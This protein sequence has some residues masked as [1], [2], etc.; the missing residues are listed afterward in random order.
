MVSDLARAGASL[1]AL[2]GR[3]VARLVRGAVTQRPR[4]LELTVTALSDVHKRATF[5]QSVRRIAHDPGVIGLLVRVESAPG[6]WASTG[7]L[8]AAFTF[9]RDH[10]KRIV[11]QLESPGNA[12]LWLASACDVIVLV[13]TGEVAP[14]GVGGE[15]TF[16]G[17]A[18]DRF[19]VRADFE[20]AGAYK[21]FGEPFTRAFASPANREATQSLLGDLHDRLLDD[22]ARGRGLE[23]AVVDALV[24][25]GPLS[26]DEALH[27]GL[28]DR[29]AYLDEVDDLF[30]DDD[31]PVPRLSFTAWARLDRIDHRLDALSRGGRKVAILHLEG[32]I[33][34]DKGG[35]TA[36]IHTRDVVEIVRALRKQDRVAAVVLNISSPGGHA[37]GSDL[38]WRELSRLADDKPLVA[39]YEDVSASGGVY[40]SAPAHRIF[41]R[42]STITGSVGVFG[43]KIVLGEG[44]RRI[45]VHTQPVGHAPHAGYF[46]PSRPFTDAQ[47]ARFRAHLQRFYDGF[48]E[49]VA[50]GRGRT[51]AQIEPACR[52]RV[53]TGHQAIAHGLVDELGDLNDAVR[54]ARSLAELPQGA[55]I[56]HVSGVPRR[57]MLQWLAQRVAP[58]AAIGWLAD[59]SGLGTLERYASLLARPAQALAL[60]PFELR[61]R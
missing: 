19:G 34:L 35:R 30:T 49:R 44:M 20:A 23:R 22:I 5:V 13:P 38:I 37:L 39:A 45:G 54:A 43:G 12:A 7:D 53:W 21:A 51:P 48:V 17:P 16:F 28:V 56:V 52:G 50:V 2:P 32:P 59:L 25:R 40:L 3:G 29:V 24:Q 26:P 42:P 6:A 15:L 14:L 8:R 55:G 27:A 10:G 4:V 9:L 60:L 1:L 33:V 46:S 11:V 47:R 41:A 31:D 36:H 58:T 18:L 57:A 61:L